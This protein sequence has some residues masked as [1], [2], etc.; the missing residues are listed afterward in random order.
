MDKDFF[1]AF[2]KCKKS[3]D[4]YIA[5]LKENSHIQLPDLSFTL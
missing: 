4:D 2:A 3:K 5:H 1:I